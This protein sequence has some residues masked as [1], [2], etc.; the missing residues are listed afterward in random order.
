METPDVPIPEVP[1]LA[2][3]EIVQHPTSGA[4]CL[5]A[6][7]EDGERVAFGFEVEGDAPGLDVVDPGL[8]L[9]AAETGE[10]PETSPLRFDA[11]EQPRADDWLQ[12]LVAHPVAAEW[13][14]GIKREHPD[15]YHRWFAQVDY[16]EGGEE[17]SG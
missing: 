16:D 4:D 15:A 14:A 2:S 17:G 1:V 12:A 7:T 5:L 3:A 11:V 9:A 13:L 10:A 8:W 6:T